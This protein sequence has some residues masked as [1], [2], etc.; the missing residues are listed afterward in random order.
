MGETTAQARDR[1]HR[2]KK[3]RRMHADGFAPRVMARVLK[4]GRRTINRDHERL[5][6]APNYRGRGKVVAQSVR[7]SRHPHGLFRYRLLAELARSAAPLPVACLTLR[8]G[9]PE[10]YRRDLWRADRALRLMERDGAVRRSK[11]GRRIA[12]ELIEPRMYMTLDDAKNLISNG[13][14]FGDV[15]AHVAPG[16]QPEL[17]EWFVRTPDL[18]NKAPRSRAAPDAATVA[19]ASGYTGGVCRSV[20]ARA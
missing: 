3:V 2:E 11:A 4:V 18:P 6:L 17:C 10:S 12:W 13:T 8:A 7:P 20:K 16:E 5:G 15:V 19:R 9:N 14:P 1:W